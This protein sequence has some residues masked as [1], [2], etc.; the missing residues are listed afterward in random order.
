[1]KNTVKRITASL[2]I[3]LVSCAGSAPAHANTERTVI[4]MQVCMATADLSAAYMEQIYKGVETSSEIL[5]KIKSDNSWS[6][7]TQ[8]QG[9]IIKGIVKYSKD[10]TEPLVSSRR[11]VYTTCLSDYK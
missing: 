3:V 2:A 9:Y 4:R 7:K 6:D 1:M 8:L 5:K 10:T 11:A